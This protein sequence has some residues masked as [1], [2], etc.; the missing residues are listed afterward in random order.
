MHKSTDA[1]NDQIQNK[2]IYN[3]YS[4]IWIRDYGWFKC[5]RDLVKVNTGKCHMVEPQHQNETQ[6]R[7]ERM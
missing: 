2:N 4:V 1:I 5:H 7:R 6:Y 3:L